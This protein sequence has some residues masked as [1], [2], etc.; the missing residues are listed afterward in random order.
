MW[1]ETE[2]RGQSGL[3][4]F[5]SLVRYISISLAALKNVNEIALLKKRER[6]KKLN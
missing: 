1:R 3:A 6:K 2:F 5:P 4:I